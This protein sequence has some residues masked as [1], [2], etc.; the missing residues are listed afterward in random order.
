VVAAIEGGKRVIMLEEFHLLRAVLAVALSTS[1][2]AAPDS[3]YDLLPD[4]GRTDV[5]V[6]GRDP[7]RDATGE[8]VRLSRGFVV[9]KSMLPDLLAK[10]RGGPPLPEP[11][12]SDA[13]LMALGHAEQMAAKRLGV[14]PEA[15]ASMSLWLWEKGLS[16]ERDRLVSERAAPDATPATI[17]A[18]RG[19]VTRL[20]TEELRAALDERRQD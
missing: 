2:Q 11:Q 12:I 5:F 18:L 16:E 4:D 9:P 10:R 3:V 15:V 20:L 1:K 6:P 7:Q 17:Q 14:T 13:S 8:F 19:R